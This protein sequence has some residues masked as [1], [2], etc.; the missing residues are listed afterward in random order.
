[1]PKKN[2]LRNGL[3]GPAGGKARGEPGKDSKSNADAKPYGP[4]S[5]GVFLHLSDGRSAVRQ[6]LSDL[7]ATALRQPAAAFHNLRASIEGFSDDG[8]QSFRLVR[9]GKTPIWSLSEG[10]GAG[11]QDKKA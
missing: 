10:R 6:L 3:R 7:E 5:G 2:S 9:Y 1:M 4:F 11:K 8:T